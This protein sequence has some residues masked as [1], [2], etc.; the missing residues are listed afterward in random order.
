MNRA[1]VAL[2]AGFV[3][4]T[5][6][7]ALAQTLYRWTD[8]SGKT[9]YG[10]RPPK[11][12]VGLTKVDTGPETN[13]LSA[14]VVPPKT[15]PAA[16]VAPKAVPADRATQ[17]RETRDRLRANLER[18]LE[19]LEQAKKK[20]AEGG[21]LQEDERQMV[22]QRAARAPTTA[23][24]HLNCRQEKGQDGKLSLMCPVSVPNDQYYERIA[25]LEGAVKQAEEEVAA[26]ESAYRRG[27]D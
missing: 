13:V 7:T 24:A 9:H 11:D 8:S 5:S 16:E 10:D 25:K 23:T 3:A 14:P 20:L 15:S 1:I 17:R 21:D 6:A 22:R 27:A 12:A 4:V 2:I 26:A 18:A 19:N